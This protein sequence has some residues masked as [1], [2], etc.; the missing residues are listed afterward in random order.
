MAAAV[1]AHA[2]DVAGVGG[3]RR[4]GVVHRLDKDTSGLLVVARTQRA[5]DSLTAQL[6]ARTV[7]RRYLAVAH[8][9]VAADGPTEALFANPGLMAA[10]RLELP[11]RMAVLGRRDPEVDQ[12]LVLSA[13]QDV[14]DGD[15]GTGG[16]GRAPAR[17]A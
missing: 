16:D 9:R 15:D 14:A 4:P 8:G 2:P 5:Y 10:H 3:P 17:R 12:A 1:L 13:H 11:Y 6:A 7:A